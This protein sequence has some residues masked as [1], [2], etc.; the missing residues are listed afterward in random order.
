MAQQNPDRP[1][2]TGKG[3]K[4][5]QKSHVRQDLWKAI[6]DYVSGT[7]YVWDEARG[8]A[9]PAPA[10]EAL[11]TFPTLTK[12]IAE[13]WREVFIAGH[14]AEFSPSEQRVLNTW[15][16]HRLR[17][18]SLSTTTRQLWNAELT[19]RVTQRVDQFFSS[20]K[21]DFAFHRQYSD[22]LEEE[23]DTAAEHSE[24]DD[25]PYSDQI[26]VAR[27]AGD[28]FSVGELL[29]R[30][31]EDAKPQ[32]Q[33]RILGQA[34][35]AWATTQGPL[36]EPSSLSE[37]SERIDNFTK[38][39]LATSFV[40]ALY[41]LR[42]ASLKVPEDIGDLSYR[43]RESIITV[44]DLDDR[45]SP[46]DTCTAAVAKL[47]TKLTEF[48]GAVQRFSRTTPAT[49]KVASIDITKLSH[50]IQPLLV[51]AE[52]DFLRDL[53]TLI[54]PAFKKL[55]QAYERNDDVEV[56]R[57][58][59]E[60]LENVGSHSAVSGDARLLSGLWNEFVDPIIKQVSTLMDVAMT[61]GEAALAPS[62]KLRNSATKADLRDSRKDITLSFTLHNSGR[63]HAYDVS[64]QGQNDPRLPRI[65]V[66]DPTG[67][68][69]IAPGSERLLRV[70]LFLSSPLTEASI[71][72]AW[73]CGTQSGKQARYEE[74]ITVTQQSTDPSWELLL[75]DPPYSVKP[76][77]APERL[78]GRDTVLQSLILAAMVGASKFIWGQ[79][80][81]GK[82]SLLQVLKTSLDGA[83]HAKCLLFRMGQLAPL[84]EG[85]IA[86]LIATEFVK[87]LGSEEV[88]PTESEFGAG[89]GR[90]VPFIELLVSVNPDA[91]FVVIID[92][93]DDLDPAF[94]TGERGKQFFKALRSLS[95]IGLTFFLPEAREWKRYINVIRLISIDGHT[96][97]WIA[98]PIK[99]IARP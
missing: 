69:G 59:P 55:C 71:P 23:L 34:I 24:P 87:R 63:G 81:I 42:K 33:P 2:E 39:N 66:V 32:I 20:Q 45:R 26:A 76:I 31:L 19:L 29:I 1:Q 22:K 50:A 8:I 70:R 80:R 65:Q 10:D 21:Q 44:Y 83:P 75:S 46:A 64:L 30:S 53:E 61:R 72:V 58:A 9:R 62:L 5:T 47:E 11:P 54:G 17:T 16:T 12:Q 36:F 99:V 56:L 18:E 88:A 97:I 37:V 89:M 94:Y 78:F 41:R 98:W 28:F 52:R 93:F 67:P 27:D 51:T 48:E 14:L 86:Y 13:E 68:F 35:I 95:E 3:P 49:A 73:I 43:L 7:R 60:L 25:T 90:L 38:E 82:T 77:R 79:K 85:Q 6:I 96:Y 91:Q 74:T 92:E 40:N 4:T 57:R 15:R 84:H